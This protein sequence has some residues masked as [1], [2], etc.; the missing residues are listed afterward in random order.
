MSKKQIMTKI[1]LDWGHNTQFALF[2]NDS[3]KYDGNDYDD[4]YETLQRL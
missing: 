4:G 3:L 1:V 2:I